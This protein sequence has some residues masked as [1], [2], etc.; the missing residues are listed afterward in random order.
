M[1]KKIFLI[2]GLIDLQ[3]AGNQT[4][5]NTVYYL[6]KAGF[7]MTVFSFLP[8]NYP[9]LLQPEEAFPNLEKHIRFY[10]LP[11]IFFLFFKIGKWF[12]NLFKTNRK[13]S[14]DGIPNFYFEPERIIDYFADLKRPG[15]FIY[16]LSWVFYVFFET[17]RVLFFSLKENPDL[18][19]GY[20]IYGARVASIM[21]KLFRKP[22]ITRFQGTALNV[23]RKSQ[24]KYFPHHVLGLKSDAD[25]I[26]MGNDGTRGKEVLIN[27][28]VP[29]DKIYFWM[30]GLDLNDLVVSPIKI[31]ELKEKYNL[32]GK[33]VLLS[34]SKL[35]IWKRIDRQIFAIYKLKRDYQ[36]QNF[37]LLIIGD[38]P[39]RKNL[40]KLVKKYD[41]ENEVRFIGPISHR[42]IA[43]YFQLA[44]VFLITNDISNLGNQIMEALYFGCLIVT[45]R[46]GSTDEILKDGYNALLVPINQIKEELPRA[47]YKILTDAKLAKTLS[48]N[49]KIT[50]REKI[51][52]WEERIKKETEVINDLIRK[53]NL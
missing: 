30:N 6:A 16:F 27:L 49:D 33:K 35:K 10:P 47:I 20:E 53:Y 17:L 12:K 32:V 28:G 3:M 21:G 51:L 34:V 45:L 44:D 14:K 50:A 13:K 25:A 40:E 18:F 19:Y 43:N 1:A 37:V 46:D 5:K 11:K 29:E 23:K 41:L 4:F 38:G 42:E 26:I 9:E 31:K 7:E 52:S 24:W 15:Q 2:S 22:V 39:E 36:M 48:E 8:D